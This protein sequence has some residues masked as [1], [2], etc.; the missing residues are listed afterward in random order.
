[1]ILTGKHN[2]HFTPQYHVAD[3]HRYYR[4]EDAE[5][6]WSKVNR[7]GAGGCWLWTLSVMDRYGHGQ[8]TV[9]RDGKQ[10]HLYAHRVAWELT[11]GPIPVPV[12]G[13]VHTAESC[14]VVWA[15]SPQKSCEV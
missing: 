5:R 10:R 8:F 2:I 13:E 12:R 11:N 1:M 14:R 4:A 9:R 6:F 7:E 3:S 15:A